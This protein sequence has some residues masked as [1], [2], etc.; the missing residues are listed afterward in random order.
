M[1]QMRIDFEKKIRELEDQFLIKKSLFE[2]KKL[3]ISN[4]EKKVNDILNDISIDVET[5]NFIEDVASTNRKSVKEKV[6]SLIN[7]A[8]HQVYGD[9]Y[10]IE[11]IYG[12]SGNKTS[13]EVKIVKK[14]KNEQVVKRDISGNGLGV[15]DLIALPLKILVLMSDKETDNILITDEP[16]KHMDDERVELFAEF[17]QKIS[18][19]LNLQ[20]ILTSHWE[21]MTEYADKIIRVDYDGN[22]SKVN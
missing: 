20:I 9:S 7:N 8:L 12:I 13:V 10:G 21:V 15:A 4:L 5:I 1:F 14:Q 17:L 22:C 6:E 2:E 3:K 11:F 19:E 18:K 16:G